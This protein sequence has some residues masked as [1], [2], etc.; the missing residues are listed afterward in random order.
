MFISDDELLLPDGVSIILFCVRLIRFSHY[1]NDDFLIRRNLIH[2]DGN[3]LVDGFCYTFDLSH[4]NRMGC[5]SIGL[6]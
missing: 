6:K 4:R 3:W 5:P 2:N 1:V